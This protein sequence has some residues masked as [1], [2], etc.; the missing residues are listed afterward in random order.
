METTNETKNIQLLSQRINN[1]NAQFDNGFITESDLEQ[2]VQDAIE[3]FH[4]GYEDW[5]RA[6]SRRVIA[7]WSF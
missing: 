3:E 2:S 6:A 1:L 5:S 7:G 4:C